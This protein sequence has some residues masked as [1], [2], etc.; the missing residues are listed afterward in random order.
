MLDTASEDL[1]AANLLLMDSVAG[2]GYSY[3]QNEQDYNISD[4]QAQTDMEATLRE[5]CQTYSYF[6]NHSVFLHGRSYAGKYVPLLGQAILKGNQ[7]G[8]KP[9]INL[10]GYLIGNGVTDS[11]TDN[12][13]IF[14]LFSAWP[15]IPETLAANLTQFNCGTLT[16]PIDADTVKFTG[17]NTTQVSACTELTAQVHSHISYNVNSMKWNG[18][19]FYGQQTFIEALAKQIAAQMAAEGIDNQVWYN[20]SWTNYKPGAGCNEDARATHMYFNRADVRQALHVQA[21]QEQAGLWLGLNPRVAAA[22]SYDIPS[23]LPQH[24][25]LISKGLRALIYSG[26][27]DWQVPWRGRGSQHWTSQL[28]A[29]LGLLAAWRPWF[30]PDP[31]NYGSH[32]AL[33]CTPL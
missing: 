4:S 11:A 13:N 7:E 33:C 24:Q 28:G 27:L 26:D 31:R 29:S 30:R 6:A 32:V 12:I 3:S 17:S 21:V 8:A 18:D 10:E 2:V 23:V 1:Q 25:F 19:C 15:L 9:S 16:N 14:S 20:Q 5:W 22:Y